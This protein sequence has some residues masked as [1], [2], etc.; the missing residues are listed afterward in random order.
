MHDDVSICELQF[1]TVNYTDLNLLIASGHGTVKLAKIARLRRVDP[2]GLLLLADC[3]N[4]SY[5]RKH[6]LSG[7]L[8]SKCEREDRLNQPEKRF[9]PLQY[10]NFRLS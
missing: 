5:T 8:M 2:N 4:R 7:S 9:I 1:G 10:R 3:Y 6:H